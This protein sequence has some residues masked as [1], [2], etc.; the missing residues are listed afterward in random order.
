MIND[1]KRLVFPTVIINESTLFSYDNA[2]ANSGN[3]GSSPYPYAV[4]MAIKLLVARV[5]STPFYL[6]LVST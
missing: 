6:T 3:S 2:N 1:T 4:Q 5:L